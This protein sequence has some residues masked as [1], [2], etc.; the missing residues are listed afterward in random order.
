MMETFS[1]FDQKGTAPQRNFSEI[2]SHTFNIY[3]KGIGW[4]LLLVVLTIIVQALLSFIAG[5]IAGYDPMAASEAMAG[6]T[7]P[8][9]FRGMMEQMMA[10]PGIK[11]YYGIS[12]ILGLL[13]Y[14][15]YAG[16]QYIFHKAN[17]GVS[18][19]FS[20]LFAGF[21]QNALQYII[22][23]LISGIAMG[24]SIML[25]F[26]PVI[27]VAPLFF[28]GMPVIFFEN[29]TA[30]EAIRKSFSLVKNNYG[31]IFGVCIISGLIALAGVIF[32][33][34][35]LLFTFPI[36]FAAMYSAYCAFVGVPDKV[37]S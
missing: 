36:Y 21:R 25:C 33:G 5:P 16:F 14:P 8:G 3:G 23:G 2:I 13:V 15:F 9:D 29:A 11:T 27:F 18:V 19:Q 31:T 12:Y 20:D 10:I 35:G 6:S 34:I 28:L 37:T 24:I 1:E 32:C 7:E 22:F 4:A 26:V 30:M 17:T